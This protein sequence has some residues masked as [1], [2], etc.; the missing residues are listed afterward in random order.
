MEQVVWSTLQI[1]SSIPWSLDIVFPEPF[2]S[3]LDL[4]SITQLNFLR[5]FSL[6]CLDESYARYHSQ[7]TITSIGPIVVCALIWIAYYIRKAFASSGS[8]SGV[9][10]EPQQGDTGLAVRKP[11]LFSEHMK[12]FLVICYICLPAV[13]MTQF[14]GLW[15]ATLEGDGTRY[16]RVDPSINCDE[17]DHK[18]FTRTIVLLIICYQVLPIQ[19]LVLLFRRKSELHPAVHPGAMVAALKDRDQDPKLAHLRFLFQVG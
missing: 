6:S 2:K 1:V 15:C 10:P 7:A 18:M 17:D 9:A 12:W 13:A 19:W 16:L 5:L 8:R 11:S 14:R 3:L 4:Y